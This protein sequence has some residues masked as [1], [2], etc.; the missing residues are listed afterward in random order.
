M[1]SHPEAG[2]SPRA[3]PSSVLAKGCRCCTRL[4]PPY[5]SPLHPDLALPKE[6][7]AWLRALIWVILE[8]VSQQKQTPK[9]PL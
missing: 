7:I 8:V 4:G 9:P 3:V 2:N 6:D 1:E 5:C